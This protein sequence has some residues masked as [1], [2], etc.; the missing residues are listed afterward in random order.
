ML[1]QGTPEAEGD[2][3]AQP[4]AGRP[5]ETLS[6]QRHQPSP[7]HPQPRGTATRLILGKGAGTAREEYFLKAKSHCILDSEGLLPPPEPSTEGA[8]EF[9]D[10][11][12]T[13]IL[14]PHTADFGF[15]L[16]LPRGTQ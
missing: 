6:G 5:A 7:S 16:K 15:A 2:W 8:P 9:T 10:L 3:L 4:A 13:W 12:P 1:S 14:L 11:V